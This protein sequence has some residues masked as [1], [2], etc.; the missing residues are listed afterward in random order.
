ML[1][2]R[3]L[4]EKAKLEFQKSS[5]EIIKNAFITEAT[6]HTKIVVLRDDSS[7]LANYQVLDNDDLMRMDRLDKR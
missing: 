2:D 3:Q 5:N 7:V 1:S 4:I 6:D